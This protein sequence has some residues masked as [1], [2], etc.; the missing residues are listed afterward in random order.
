[1]RVQV[2]RWG[3]SLAVRIPVECAREAGI[4]AGDALEVD[5]TSS[6][7]VRLMHAQASRFD[8]LAFLKQLET[9]HLQE[10]TGTTVVETMRQEA[11][12]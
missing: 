1:M 12:Y 2:A 9:L 5:V 10:K 3:N 6:G 11:R 8:K 7:D 4:K